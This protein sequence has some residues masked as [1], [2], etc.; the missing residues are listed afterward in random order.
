MKKHTDL[1]GF[2]VLDENIVRK[3]IR[4]VI[5]EQQCRQ[6]SQELADSYSAEEL[7][8]RLDQ[9]MRDME[10]EAEPEGGPISDM[11]ADEMDAYEGAIRIARGSSD[12]PMT[13]DQAIGRD[14]SE[15]TDAISTARAIRSG[16]GEGE[17]IGQTSYKTRTDVVTAPGKTESKE[18][19]IDNTHTLDNV[20][21][22]WRGANHWGNKTLTNLNFEPE[23][24]NEEYDDLMAI[25]NDSKW[26]FIVDLDE[27]TGEPDWDTLMIDSRELENVAD[28]GTST[29]SVPPEDMVEQG[30]DDRFKGAMG[31][32]GFSDD[33]QDDIMSRDVGS[34]FPG[35]D[36][37]GMAP[38]YSPFAAKAKDYIDTFRQEY[39]DMSD[40]GIDEFSVEIM[41][42]LLN[43][44][45]AQ[46]TAKI[47]FGK[48][49]L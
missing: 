19:F 28:D 12:T 37:A 3:Q 2:N 16:L 30:F 41:N 5:K 11:Y 4:Q 7:Q 14:T 39:R 42:H 45:A 36:E 34:R 22:R 49:G 6:K 29:Y 38:R 13:Y 18:I 44:T 43:N 10:Q 17:K 31:D 26:L 20:T 25:S 9:I 21:I 15:G 32:A 35:E 8:S 48:R 47:F 27:E 40:D 33:E 46:A 1:L 24:A 23:F